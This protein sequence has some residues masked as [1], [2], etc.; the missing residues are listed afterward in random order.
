LA[1]CFFAC[2]FTISVI[3][4]FIQESKSWHIAAFLFSQLIELAIASLAFMI[5]GGAVY[6][7]RTRPLKNTNTSS[8]EENN[9]V[10]P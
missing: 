1:G 9:P 4:K 5:V 10:N 7:F 2:A 3:L 6:Y 8:P